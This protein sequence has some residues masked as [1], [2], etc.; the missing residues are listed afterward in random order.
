VEAHAGLD[1]PPAEE[2]Y[3]DVPGGALFTRTIGRGPVVVVVHG[4]PGTLDHT[5][6]LPSMDVLADVGRLVY[7]DQR[8]HG[9]SLGTL[10][11]SDVTMERFVADLA[12]VC[13]AVGEAAVTLLGHSWGAHVALRFALRH[14]ERVARIVLMNA[15]PVSR[16]DY[17]DFVAHR[18]ARAGRLV[19]EIRVLM[20]TPA[21]AQGDP[22]L[23]ADLFRRIFSI[24]IAHPMDVARLHLRF[25]RENVKRGRTI[26]QEFEATLFSQP[27]DLLPKLADLTVPTLVLHGDQDFVPVSIANHI[28]AAVPRSR[29]A[30]LPACGH[31]AYLEASDAVHAEIAAFIQGA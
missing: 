20:A 10:S 24:G 26:A 25:S 4:G 2:R 6:L 28:A 16:S 30:V 1:G 7:Y 13:S 14:T 11:S 23:E 21:Y 15:G 12:A 29:L 8:G 18:R 22:D 5:Y 3:V 27:F 19:D 17:Q 31:F 9:R